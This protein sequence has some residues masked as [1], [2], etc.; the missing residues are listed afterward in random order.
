MAKV[1]TH[2][3]THTHSHTHARARARAP[4][5]LGVGVLV[6][7]RADEEDRADASW[8]SLNRAL[9]NLGW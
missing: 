3:H 9:V 8:Y 6:A 7:G 5:S 2:T 4:L 1:A